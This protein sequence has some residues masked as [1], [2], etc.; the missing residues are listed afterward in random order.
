MDQ[1]R[2]D[3]GFGRIFDVIFGGPVVLPLVLVGALALDQVLYLVED[4]K[5]ILRNVNNNNNNK[6]NNNN[7]D[8][9]NNNSNNNNK[10]NDKKNN[11]NNGNN[12]GNNNN[13]NNN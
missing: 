10:N 9:N 12:N 5:V 7:N 4:V 2:I 1:E 3:E 11:N 8:N 6:N 13:N